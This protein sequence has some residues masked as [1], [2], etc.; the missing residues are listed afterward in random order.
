[1]TID[2]V[3]RE[4]RDRL[5]DGRITAEQF[6]MNTILEDEPTCGSLGCIGG[7]GLVVLH[8]RGLITLDQRDN[9]IALRNH[10]LDRVGSPE[11][12]H[13]RYSSLYGL[14]F[15][16]P[17]KPETPSLSQAVQAIDAWLGGCTDNPWDHVS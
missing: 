3:M 5:V 4:V 17:N 1:M 7:W 13:T 11:N 14:F 6:Q 12:D 16:W 8:E 10:F 15:Q 2:E 9:A